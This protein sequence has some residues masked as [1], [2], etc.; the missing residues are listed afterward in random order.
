LTYPNSD[1]H[2]GAVSAVNTGEAGAPGT[3]IEVTPEMIEAGVSVFYD[4]CPEL[5]MPPMLT[6]RDLVRRKT[7]ISLP[8]FAS[9]GFSCSLKR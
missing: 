8:A 3:K 2:T 4:L 1:T 9:G 6:A 7:S 5:E